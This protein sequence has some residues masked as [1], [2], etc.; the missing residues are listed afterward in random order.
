MG[1]LVD[2]LNA[3]G[4]EFKDSILVLPPWVKRIKFDIG[5]AF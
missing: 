5:L 4:F 1:N 2:A 3:Y